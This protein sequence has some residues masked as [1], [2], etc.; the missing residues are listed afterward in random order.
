[1]DLSLHTASVG[2]LSYCSNIHPGESWDEVLNS[3]RL[4]IPPI[5]AQL[6]PK[7]PFGIGLR[8]SAVAAQ[9]LARPS[10]IAELL[11]FLADHHCYVYTINGFPYGT[12]HGDAVKENVYLPDWTDAARLNYSNTLADVFA[13]ILPPHMTGSISTVP[14]AFKSSVQRESDV[15]QMTDYFIQQA[16]YLVGIER[17]T[18]KHIV[19]ALEPE[20]C[21]YLE[22][23]E[24]SIEYFDQHLYGAS[25]CERFAKLTHV[26]LDV[27]E[28][29]LRSHLTLCLDLCHAA[30]EF[31]SCNNCID[32]LEN[33]G[34]A[35]GKVQ[36]SS[37]LRLPNLSAKNKHLLEP[38][39]DK[40]YLHQVVEQHNGTLNRF[41]DLPAALDALDDSEQ[42]REWRVHFHVPIF[43][44]N[45][46]DFSSTRFFVEQAL[47]R[48]AIKPI[49][50]HLEIETYTW[51]VLPDVYRTQSI[52]DAIVREFNWVID[53]L[54]QQQRIA[55]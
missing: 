8:L 2:H 33:A 20:P 7:A 28:D 49:S 37:G 36:I 52:D 46:G 26:T 27:A 30:V 45:L 23:I 3:L 15:E 5:K 13:Q 50:E 24:E 9:D 48:H 11:E 6:S 21:C 53:S 31:E 39:I 40:V 34:I 55:A 35:I 43:L 47:Q 25:A 54:R 16:A 32:A 17:R 29:L 4:H 12:F 41:E 22:T 42:E 44:D 38:F 14:G 51:D 1:M 18:G 10:A 19:L